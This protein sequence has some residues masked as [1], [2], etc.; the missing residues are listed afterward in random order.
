MLSGT[1]EPECRGCPPTTVP[2]LRDAVNGAEQPIPRPATIPTTA[3]DPPHPEAT[4]IIA[5][6]TIHPTVNGMAT[7]G[8]L[9]GSPAVI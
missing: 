7:A 1:A 8:C 6:A 3:H 2:A 9:T 4:T 5:R